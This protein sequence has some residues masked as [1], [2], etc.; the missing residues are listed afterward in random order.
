MQRRDKPGRKSSSA[1]PV[2][3]EAQ[4][5]ETETEAGG[6]E[7]TLA[8]ALEAE[9]VSAAPAAVE[10]AP[11]PA[12]PVETEE[13]PPA[14]ATGAPEPKTVPT[15]APAPPEQ[16]SQ[17]AAPAAAPR[18]GR[19]TGELDQLSPDD[20]QGRRLQ[21]LLGRQQ[22]LPLD[23]GEAPEKGPGERVPAE[24]REELIERLLDPVLSIGETATLLGVC[25]TSVRR[26]TNRG[27]LK[28]FR[29]PGNQRRF[30]LSDVLDFMEQQQEV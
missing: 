30:R 24:S 6:S 12:L 21:A 4:H 17:P 14:G 7:A 13:A 5:R 26:Y 15:D 19:V 9:T 18:S 23:L 3:E 25:P 8:E 20:F 29:T 27:V 22:R 11:A 10:T 28:C 16:A 2:E 1:P